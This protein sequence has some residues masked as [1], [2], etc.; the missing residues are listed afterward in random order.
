MHGRS[1]TSGTARRASPC[2]QGGG[3]PARRTA[4][5]VVRGKA[6]VSQPARRGRAGAGGAHGKSAGPPP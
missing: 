1:R 2:G 6:A 4:A 3:A 5:G